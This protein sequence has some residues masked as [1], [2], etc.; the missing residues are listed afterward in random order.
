MEQ[1]KAD[2][3]EHDL[4]EDDKTVTGSIK[5]P[6]NTKKGGK[7]PLDHG[8][9]DTE[10]RPLHHLLLVDTGCVPV[11]DVVVAEVGAEVHAEPDAHD[12]VDQGD[13]VKDDAPH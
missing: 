9:V 10:H 1:P 7:S 6:Y 5:H 3:D 8:L 11:L 12:Q 2:D 13:S 4:E